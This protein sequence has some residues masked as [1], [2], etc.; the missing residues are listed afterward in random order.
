[1][2][3]SRQFVVDILA[4]QARYSVPSI[5]ASELDNGYLARGNKVLELALEGKNLKLVLEWTFRL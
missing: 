1:M 2:V 3:R 5:E 4:G